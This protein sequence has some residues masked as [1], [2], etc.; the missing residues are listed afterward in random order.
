VE[1]RSAGAGQGSEFVVRLPAAPQEPA[2]EQEG[3]GT[4]QADPPPVPARRVL[5]VDDNVDAAD[6][7]ALLLKLTGQEVR[8]AHDGPT[9]LLVA[10]AFRPQVVLLDIGMPGMDGY[11]V[12]RRL[13]G[14]PEGRSALV[15]ALTGWGQDHDRRRSAEAGFDHH[16]VKPV[17]PDALGKLLAGCD[18]RRS[19]RSGA[20]GP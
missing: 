7:L 5:V 9:A 4:A 2:A 3:D 12:A 13:R 17:E 18:P 20:D 6:S 19:G 1:A 8:V 15:V 14:Q 16:L 10:E 11:E